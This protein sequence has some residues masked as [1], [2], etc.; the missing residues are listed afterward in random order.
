MT[1][2]LL[3][4]AWLYHADTAQLTAVSVLRNALLPTRDRF[5]LQITEMN[6]KIKRILFYIGIGITLSGIGTIVSSP[7]F[8]EKRVF[9][10]ETTDEIFLTSERTSTE[11]EI[12]N[13]VTQATT[14]KS[15]LETTNYENIGSTVTFATKE[16]TFSSVFTNTTSDVGFTEVDSTTTSL[17]VE[18]ESLPF[19]S[20]NVTSKVIW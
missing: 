5:F 16:S 17:I 18:E 2:S 9:E 15:S 6:R 19:C 10:Q 1:T 4:A 11:E 13:T 14:D 3:F 8:F 7:V 12:L 20:E